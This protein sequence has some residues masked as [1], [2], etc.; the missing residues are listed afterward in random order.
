MSRVP[1]S[2]VARVGGQKVCGETLEAV[3]AAGPLRRQQ[4]PGR[5]HCHAARCLLHEPSAIVGKY[6]VTTGVGVLDDDG[7]CSK[8]AWR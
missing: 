4:W 3:G 1:R 8:G 5:N 6:D 7:A 2:L